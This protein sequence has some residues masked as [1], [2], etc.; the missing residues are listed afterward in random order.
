VV[1]GCLLAGSAG[2][3]WTLPA[4]LEQTFQPI[5]GSSGWFH[6]GRFTIDAK[7][8]SS[9]SLEMMRGPMMQVILA[10]RFKLR[11]HWETREFSTYSGTVPRR[12]FSPR[13]GRTR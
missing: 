5:E 1:L 8:E 9:V 4:S 13:Q 11:I 3:P 6:S 12:S 2:K 7:A 10:D